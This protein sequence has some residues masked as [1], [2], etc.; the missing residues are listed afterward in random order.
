MKVAVP[1]AIRSRHCACGRLDCVWDS[2]AIAAGRATMETAAATA[3]AVPPSSW[4]GVCCCASFVCASASQAAGGSQVSAPMRGDCDV[5]VTHATA[6]AVT[7]STSCAL[8]SAQVRPLHPPHVNRRR[9][10]KRALNT[11]SVLSVG[12]QRSKSIDCPLHQQAQPRWRDP[13]R[14]PRQ[15]VTTCWAG[16]SLDVERTSVPLLPAPVSP[17]PC[18]VVKLRSG[19]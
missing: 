15:S 8:A 14:H 18:A 16:R 6:V 9:G 11:H 10:G 5:G 7:S 13:Q 2:R 1:S 4:R 19:R 17:F 12:T 3:N